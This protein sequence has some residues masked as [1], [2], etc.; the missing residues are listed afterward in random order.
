MSDE[1][2][3]RRLT[4]DDP[5]SPEALQQLANLS[6]ARV[7]FCDRNASLDQEKIAI[8]AAL[9]RLDDQKVK[10]FESLLVERGL[11][12][13]TEVTIN[14]RTGKVQLLRRMPDGSLTPKPPPAEPPPAESGGSE[15][16]PEPVHATS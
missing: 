12:P 13:D 11:A 14:P 3:P 15:E 2:E 4:L 8:L 10:L 16:A 1:Q 7:D 5:V 6:N 9:K